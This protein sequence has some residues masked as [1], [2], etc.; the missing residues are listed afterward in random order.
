M[1]DTDTYFESSETI[2][3]R[4]KS[5]ITNVSTIEGSDIHNSQAPVSVELANTKLQLDEIFKKVFAKSALENGYSEWLEKRCEE[6]GIYRKSG[7]KATGYIT[8]IGQAGATILANTIVQTQTGLRYFTMDNAVIANGT[9]S[10]KVKVAAEYIGSAYNKIANT[11]TYLP[12]RLINITSITNEEA[13]ENGYDVES[14]EDLCNR[15]IVKIQTPA[16]SGNENHYKNW[17]LEVVGVGDVKIFSET[18]LA[19]EHQNGCVKVVIVNSNKLGADSTLVSNVLTHIEENRPIGCTPYVVSATEKAINVNAAIVLSD[20]YLIDNVKT[21]IE[22]QLVDYFKSVAFK[23]TYV[24]YN[25][26]GALIYETEGVEDYSNL[27]VNNGTI[28]IP[29]GDIE[30]PVIGSVVAA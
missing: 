20:G 19:G 18:N 29:L 22:N 9:T 6:F 2:L 4:M 15:Y 16:T 25:K 30:I 26:I 28:N 27:T 17:A 13:F 11:I 8:F 24:S 21:N 14:N 5:G 7:D 23:K 10:I 12:I 3:N 1:S